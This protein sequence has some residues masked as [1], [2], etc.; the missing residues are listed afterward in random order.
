MKLHLA[1]NTT[2][3]VFTGYGPGYVAVNGVRYE[4]SVVVMPERILD[5][6]NVPSLAAL[7]SE[8]LGG[9]ALLQ[10]ELILLGTGTALRFPEPRIFAS[11]T[12]ARVGIEVM[13]TQAACRT[14]NILEQ[15]GR[16][17][18]AALIMEAAT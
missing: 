4:K 11:L 13:D 6:W 17:V 7:T 15:E 16:N 14:F 18:A 5:D 1:R 10:P 3:N 9:L 2:R 8:L 12:S